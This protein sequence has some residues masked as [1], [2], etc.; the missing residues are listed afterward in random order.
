MKTV[1]PVPVFRDSEHEMEEAL[2]EIC[3]VP[4]AL[5]LLIVVLPWVTLLQCNRAY[6]SQ[7]N[8]INQ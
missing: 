7:K 3:I 4:M 2:M 6:G 8:R 5:N 1:E